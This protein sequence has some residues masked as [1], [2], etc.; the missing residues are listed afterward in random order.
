MDNVFV[1]VLFMTNVYIPSVIPPKKRFT[2]VA[3]AFVVLTVCL[4]L[5]LSE[6]G[7]RLVIPAKLA[8]DT[9]FVTDKLLDFVHFR[10]SRIF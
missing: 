6:V 7:V 10:K 1:V 2:P 3:P 5:V 9:I 4:V 8:S